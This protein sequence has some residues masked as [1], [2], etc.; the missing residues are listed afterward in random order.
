[1]SRAMGQL[2]EAL[3]RVGM[4]L[5]LPPHGVVLMQLMLDCACQLN[6]FLPTQ[7]CS[8]LPLLEVLLSSKDSLATQLVV[9]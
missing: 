3:P 5:V 1:M 6:T 7:A 4:P 2:G 8:Q 9:S